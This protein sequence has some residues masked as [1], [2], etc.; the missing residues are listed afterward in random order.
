MKAQ[1]LFG[2]LSF[3]LAAYATCEKYLQH[4]TYPSRKHGAL[5]ITGDEAKPAIVMLEQ[6][7]FPV[8]ASIREQYL[9]IARLIDIDFRLITED[10]MTITPRQR[11]IFLAK[12]LDEAGIA[13][14]GLHGFSVGAR[15]ALAFAAM[16]PERSL[17]VVND[18]MSH[19]R[20]TTSAAHSHSFGLG[21]AIDTLGPELMRTGATESHHDILSELMDGLDLQRH[22]ARDTTKKVHLARIVGRL[23]ILSKNA[24]LSLTESNFNDQSLVLSTAVDFDQSKDLATISERNIPLVVL[25]NGQSMSGL[26][27]EFIAN[28]Y[29]RAVVLPYVGHGIGSQ[30]RDSFRS[31]LQELSGLLAIHQAQNPG[32]LPVS[33]LNYRTVSDDLARK[34]TIFFIHGL[35]GDQNTWDEVLTS[36]LKNHFRLVTMDLRGHGQSA[37]IGHNA[38]LDTMA[39]DLI[40]LVRTISRPGEPRYLVGHSLGGRVAL[41]MASLDPSIA[42][43]I[44]IEDMHFKSVRQAKSL[45]AMFERAEKLQ[46]V[47]PAEGWENFNAARQSIAGVM[48]SDFEADRVVTQGIDGRFYLKAK[49]TFE[50]AIGEEMGPE[51]MKLR[52][53]IS[54][55]AADPQLLNEHQRPVAFLRDVGIRHIEENLPPGDSLDLHIFHGSGHSIH[56]ELPKAYAEFLRGLFGN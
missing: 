14:V 23:R 3:S 30:H 42:E 15:S 27:T 49:M 37:T 34:G 32:A 31:L 38:N 8:S 1:I 52:A 36:D 51:L 24:A 29:G 50:T 56:S 11:A 5:T 54:F 41:R 55:I 9:K 33:L 26:D 2:M 47:A 13:K 44:T 16:F 20:L 45:S 43:H 18:G 40:H 28:H 46:S 21:H 53:R 12:K 22:L 6:P 4:N 19:R 48:P 10:E 7:N 25:N 39:H 17:F 35:G